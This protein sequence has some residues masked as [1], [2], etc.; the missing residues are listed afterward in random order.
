[1]KDQNLLPIGS[2]VYLN[3]GII[4]LMIIARQ[5]IVNINE[6]KCYMDYA[7]INQLTGLVSME[8]FAYFNQ[9]DISDVLYEGFVGENEER[10]LSA[11]K[12]W[13]EKN[14]HISKGRVSEI[15]DK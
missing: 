10:V 4:P 13:R 15:I 9:E 3:E 11:L 7:A 14:T 8:E 6:E 12:E 1:M 5:P 2:V